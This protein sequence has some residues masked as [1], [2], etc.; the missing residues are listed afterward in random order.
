MQVTVIDLYT[1]IRLYIGEG[2]PFF[3]FFFF[4]VWIFFIHIQ[5]VN[6]LLCTISLAMIISQVGCIVWFQWKII[7]VSR[8]VLGSLAIVGFHQIDLMLYCIKKCTIAQVTTYNH[9]LLVFY[10]G[11]NQL[12]KKKGLVCKSPI[13]LFSVCQKKRKRERKSLGMEIYERHNRARTE[14]PGGCGVAVVVYPWFCVVLSTSY[15][16]II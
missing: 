1:R 3:F 10:S 11:L 4:G 12:E 15:F 6:M 13:I 8:N 5:H 2:V 16:V 9:I 14:L 7:F